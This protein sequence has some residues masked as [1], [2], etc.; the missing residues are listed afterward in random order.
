LICIF[1]IFRI[2]K[3]LLELIFKLAETVL[4]FLKK[5]LNLKI[6]Q[7]STLWSLKHACKHHY[8]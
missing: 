6:C 5:K 1:N 4:L 7:I 8:A 3:V 2:L